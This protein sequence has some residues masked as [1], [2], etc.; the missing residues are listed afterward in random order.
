MSIKSTKWC[1]KPKKDLH[2]ADYK[3]VMYNQR[4]EP[5]YKCKVCGQIYHSQELGL[6][7]KQGQYKPKRNIP[8]VSKIRKMVQRC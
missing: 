2:L 7:T 4:Q 8:S 3:S 5:R 1:V 6:T